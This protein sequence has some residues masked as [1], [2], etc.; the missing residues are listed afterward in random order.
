MKDYPNI[1]FYVFPQLCADLVLRQD[2]QANHDSVILNTGGKEPSIKI[3]NLMTLDAPQPPLF[4]YI[5]LDCKLIATKSRSYS[6]ED[7]NFI[8]SEKD[9]LVSE[10]IIEPRSLPWRSQ[11][12][13]TKNEQHK[14]RLVIDSSQTINKYTNLDAYQLPRTDD[15]VN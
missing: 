4:H 1:K 8:R 11:V 15:T 7:H 9:Y 6:H 10:G 3:C 13:V 12:V 14:K 5:S 2:W